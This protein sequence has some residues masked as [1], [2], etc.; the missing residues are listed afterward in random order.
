MWICKGRHFKG[1]IGC[2]NRDFKI[3]NIWLIMEEYCVLI[4]SKEIQRM[5][6]GLEPGDKVHKNLD[7]NTFLSM[8]F[9]HHASF[10]HLPRSRNVIKCEPHLLS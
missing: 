7:Y 9:L 6:R 10:H 4:F 1:S 3:P 5:K 2:N 8:I